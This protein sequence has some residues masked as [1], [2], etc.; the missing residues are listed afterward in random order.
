MILNHARRVGAPEPSGAS[1][2]AAAI[3]N[4]TE[5]NS[6]QLVGRST[7]KRKKEHESNGQAP[8]RV[9]STHS[10]V[11]PPSITNTVI[12]PY[13]LRRSP[14]SLANNSSSH[15]RKERALREN[16]VDDSGSSHS[17]KKRRVHLEAKPT[18]DS[19][20][21][22]VEE[23]ADIFAPVIRKDTET[24]AVGSSPKGTVVARQRRN[25]GQRLSGDGSG[26]SR[27]HRGDIQHVPPGSA[28]EL[29]CKLLLASIRPWSEIPVVEMAVAA[30][31]PKISSAI[32]V[33][34]TPN[35]PSAECP[36]SEPS[37]QMQMDQLRVQVSNLHVSVQKLWA[38]RASVFKEMSKLRDISK[39]FFLKSETMASEFADCVQTQTTSMDDEYIRS[40]DEAVRLLLT[41]EA[42][43]ANPA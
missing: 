31:V 32:S 4:A 39:D 37:L 28:D 15:K 20:G 16:Q 29:T 2:I 7:R 9:S 27:R 22:I 26:S 33:L 34:P 1:S 40:E 23:N 6:N 42:N 35:K 36:P 18:R 12:R 25:D 3:N 10:Q 14:L 19:S 17:V 24:T 21:V 5:S 30:S 38:S 13:G 8:L 43:L 41:K 11:V